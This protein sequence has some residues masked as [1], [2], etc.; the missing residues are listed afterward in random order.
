MTLT[1]RAILYWTLA[2]A[3]IFAIGVRLP[4]VAAL[5]LSIVP[6]AAYLLHRSNKPPR[7][8]RFAR[9]AFVLV[10]LVPPYVLSLGPVQMAVA[11]I[12]ERGYGSTQEH[13]MWWRDVVYA[14]TYAIGDDGIFE[15]LWVNYV[16]QWHLYGYNL[17]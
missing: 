1:L 7:R 13:V 15:A 5:V 4:S 9:T 10:L 8:A 6:L 11:F 17:G 3:V 2:A 12:G 16:V 14:P